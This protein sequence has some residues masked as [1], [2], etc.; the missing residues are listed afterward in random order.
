MSLDT[1]AEYRAQIADRRENLRRR[2]QK[3]VPGPSGFVWEVG[4][5]HGH[6]LVAFA[7]AHPGEVCIGIDIA[8]D[9]VRRS[10]RKRERARLANLHFFLADSG[11]FLAAMP[12]H[13]V[14]SAV[15]LLFPDP[16]PKRRHHKNRVM[17]P[18]FLA[19]I[20]A[21]TKKGAVLCFRT[22][23]EPYFRDVLAM[24]R[25]HRG[26]AEAAGGTLPF[27]EATVFQKRAER[28]FTLVATRLS[29]KKS[30]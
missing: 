5:G 14:F 30:A 22:D 29:D 28:H 18:E 3:I 10:E 24:V 16:W 12:E 9:R 4:S 2:L 13:A 25:A 6:F 8:S 15:Y 7:A 20:S 27:E 1:K 19:T 17:N 11:D 23:H 21:R 26:W